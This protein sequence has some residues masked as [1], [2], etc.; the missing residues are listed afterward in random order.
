MENLT[1]VEDEVK[2]FD[3]FSQK[4]C[5]HNVSLFFVSGAPK[6]RVEKWNNC[7]YL[8]AIVSSVAKLARN[9]FSAK[10]KTFSYQ[11]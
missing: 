8:F 1:Y 2:R 4:K 11:S 9:L 5:G 10:Q 6:G 3:L 7:L